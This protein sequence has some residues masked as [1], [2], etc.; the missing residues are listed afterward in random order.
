MAWMLGLLGA[1]N[2]IPSPYYFQILDSTNSFNPFLS[3]PKIDSSGNLYIAAFDN[4]QKAIFLKLDS[5][6]NVSLAKEYNAANF[7]NENNFIQDDGTT[8][9]H[10]W[11]PEFGGSRN[12][13]LKRNSSGVAQWIKTYHTGSL[14]FT[15]A[16]IA[17][18]SE[19]INFALSAYTGSSYYSAI[20]SL[21]QNGTIAS[22]MLIGTDNS[23]SYESSFLVRNNS[24]YVLSL[25]ASHSSSRISAVI[26]NPYNSGALNSSR[27]L[28][29]GSGNKVYLRGG[30]TAYTGSNVYG[31]YGCGD[32]VPSGSLEYAFITKINFD[33]FIWQKKLGDGVNKHF[34]HSA[35]QNSAGDIYAAGRVNVGIVTRGLLVKYDSDGNLLWQ[36]LITPSAA[37]LELHTVELDSN[38]DIILTGHT[39]AFGGN[40]DIFYANLPADGSATKT[41]TINGIDFSYS[42]HNAVASNTAMSST[43]G[44]IT[45]TQYS[46]SKSDVSLAS[47]VTPTITNYLQSI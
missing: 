25:G 20:V 35:V 38:E 34:F 5:E 30:G 9:F 36:R 28:L 19:W 24:G 42:A 40:N 45:G 44:G 43:T 47:D 32:F 7:Y 6:K 4:A 46:A 13:V 11:T 1:I 17:V 37:G 21:N 33:S 2:G 16:G 22:Q 23:S 26:V 14:E 10:G 41:I 18:S 12:F 3:R 29:A 39:N 15:M 8:F 31:G 27:S